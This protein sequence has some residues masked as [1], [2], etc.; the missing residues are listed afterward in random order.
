M[1]MALDSMAQNSA[2]CEYCCELLTPKQ[3]RF[4]SLYG[5]HTQSRIVYEQNNF[6][7]MPTLG[8]LFK[9]SLLIFPKEHVERMADLPITELKN[10]ISFVSK[11]ERASK[12]L[13]TPLLF[14]H[15]AKC[16]SNAGCGIYHAHFH[17]V[18][19]P[20]GAQLDYLS[21]LPQSQSAPD[22]LHAFAQLRDSD[23]YLF[24]RD[25]NNTFAFAK[26][27]MLLPEMRTSQYIRRRLTRMF[28]LP[29]HWD[30]RKYAYP[31]PW[32]LETLKQFESYDFSFGE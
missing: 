15:G 13:G 22:M 5:L 23:V 1:E 29:G 7:A 18:P 8:Q 32:L 28:D 12:S 27:E 17:L 10:L 25:T 2:T 21:I 31:E 11:I 19:L 14:E 6:V 20:H 9:G 30:W 26:D 24:V 3:S 4:S 16:E